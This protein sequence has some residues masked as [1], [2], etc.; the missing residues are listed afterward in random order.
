MIIVASSSMRQARFGLPDERLFNGMLI[1]TMLEC[2]IEPCTFLIDGHVGVGFTAANYL[3]NTALFCFNILFAFTWTLYVDYKIFNDLSRFKRIYPFIALPALF[4][5]VGSIINLFHPVFYTISADNVYSRTP[6]YTITYIF[7]YFYLLYGVA[8]VYI[9]RGQ[10]NR[11]MFLPAAFFMIPIAIGSI[12]QFAFYGLSLVW[13][14]AS[15]AMVSLY[16]NVQKEAA[17]VDQL[18]GLYS[19]QYFI[20][21]LNNEFARPPHEDIFAGIMLDIDRFKSINDTFGHRMGDEAIAAVGSLL[22][23]CTHKKAMAARYAGDEFVVIMRVRSDEEVK[24][25]MTCID[26]ACRELS[27]AHTNPFELTMSMGYALRLGKDD[28]VDGFLE[29]MD[30]KMYEQKHLL[31]R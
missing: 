9:F 8:L 31:T 13:L 2:I 10:T 25:M 11:Y 14:S 12:L 5:C 18:S 16:I 28:T 22:R 1:F 3:L 20:E 4:V 19:R 27:E 21:C 15:I 23:H 17:S 6:L 24:R 7:T 26:Q 29:R 30:S